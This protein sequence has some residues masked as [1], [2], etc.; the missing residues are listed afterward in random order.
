MKKAFIGLLFFSLALAE[1]NLIPNR[2]GVDG[3][4]IGYGV[5]SQGRA[6]GWLNY[7]F[8]FQWRL[9]TL[10]LTGTINENTIAKVEFD[11]AHLFLRDLYID[12]KLGRGF[13]IRTGQFPL[14]I[15]FE[16]ETPERDL[17]LEEHSLLYWHTSKPNTVRDIGM[18]FKW[19]QPCSTPALRVM[20]ALVNG[21][22]PNIGDNNSRKDIF[23]RAVVM[24]WSGVNLTFGG[25][26]YYGWVNPEAV[27]WLGLGGELTYRNRAFFL[28]TELA[29]RRHKNIGVP[30]GLL[31]LS[32]QAAFLDPALRLEAMRW[33][34]GKLQWRA[35]TALT[36]KPAGE[37]LKVLIGYQYNTL[38]TV[39]GY[40]GL[41]VQIIAGF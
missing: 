41:I 27:R 3:L 9:G 8:D 13:E 24:P 38:S 33:D 6:R 32:Y 5:I 4:F 40:Q 22:G 20:A 15:N 11:F 7:G 16:A 25:R 26:G 1:L 35:L 14:P 2:L 31:E 18:L 30:A 21:A 12:F 39:W 37:N 23:V 19:N 17:K 29:Y 28:G 10:S 36:M 34:D